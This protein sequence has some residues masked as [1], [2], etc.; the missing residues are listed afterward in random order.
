MADTGNVNRQATARALVLALKAVKSVA[1]LVVQTHRVYESAS[2]GSVGLKQCDVAS[3][4]KCSGATV[5][6]LEQGKGIPIKRGLLSKILKQCGFDMRSKH[7]GAGL[8]ALL[9][10]IRDNEKA[11]ERIEKEPPP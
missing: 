2:R 10:V 11:I 5:S 1:G 4:A 6:N 3:K 8:L 7:G 9:K